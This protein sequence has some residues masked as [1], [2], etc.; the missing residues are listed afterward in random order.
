MA[1]STNH[2]DPVEGRELNSTKAVEGTLL[3]DSALKTSDSLLSALTNLNQNMDHMAGSLIVMGKAFAALSK[4]RS[5]K[6]DA[7]SGN[8]NTSKGK[9]KS[10][11]AVSY[12]EETSSESDDA[13]VHEL[14]AT[15]M[16]NDSED[17][18]TSAVNS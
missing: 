9:T 14:L 17:A 11:V 13:D 8:W 16:E 15:S 1:N 18:K 10:R 2:E 4:Q 3:E 6:R 12:T 5:V 7:R